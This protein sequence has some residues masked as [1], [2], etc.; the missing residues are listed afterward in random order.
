MFVS[1]SFLNKAN[2]DF[3]PLFFIRIKS[4]WLQLC[5]GVTLIKYKFTSVSNI[6]LRSMNIW[7]YSNGFYSLL[8]NTLYYV[9]PI[10][11][12]N[13]KI[14]S[15]RE[16]KLWITD[17]YNNTIYL[18]TKIINRTKEHVQKN[19]RYHYLNTLI[20][21]NCVRLPAAVYFSKYINTLVLSQTISLFTRIK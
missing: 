18:L 15:L 8:F 5:T 4:D 21:S 10:D 2:F 19:Q 17:Q 6:S 12:I 20:C 9:H 7:W 14:V 16:S 1:F 11:V 3:W 13:C